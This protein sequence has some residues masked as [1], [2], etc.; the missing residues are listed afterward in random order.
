MMIIFLFVLTL[1]PVM[2]Q[3]GFPA[4]A[5]KVGYEKSKRAFVKNCTCF[6]VTVSV[7][8]KDY[9]LNSGQEVNLNSDRWGSWTWFAGSIGR[10]DEKRVPFPVK[11]KMEPDFGANSVET[12][13][14]S[15]IYS[16]DF[17]VPEGT[18]IFAVEEGV[19]ARIVHHYREAHQ[20]KNRMEEV[21]RVLIVH[22]DGSAAEYAHLQAG[23]VNLKLCERVSLGQLI[24]LS[25]HNGFS[26]GPH[27]HLQVSRPIGEGKSHSISLRFLTK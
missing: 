12:H 16:Y 25:G 3:I 4:D 23:S 1:I 8:G 9:S 17:S 24:G 7:N 14:G 20:D 21:N 11:N 2:G 18:S 19:V 22:P 10:M 6:P 15:N 13:K 5:V 27:L 26:S